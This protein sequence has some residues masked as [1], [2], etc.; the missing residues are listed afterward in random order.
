M[1]IS[2]FSAENKKRLSQQFRFGLESEYLVV[3][4]SDYQALWH[5][6]LSFEQLNG[7]FE[8]I[9]LDGIPSCEG[10]DLESPQTKLMP[11]VVEGYHLPDMDF[12]AKQILPKGVEIRTPVCNT[13]TQAL[14]IHSVLYKRLKQALNF[15]D[16]DLVSLSHH[17]H[18]S[19]FSG[20]Q[21]KRR[22]DYWQWSMEVMTTYGPDINVGI[23]EE[24]VRMISVDDLHQ[25]INYYGP[26]LS[27]L[28][29]ASPFCNGE[30]W[31][32]AK[33]KFGKSYRM[34]KRSYI[35][36]PIEIHFDENNRFEFKV[37]DMPNSRVE[38]EAQILSFLILII[39]DALTG[40]AT[41]QTRIY[42]L[43]EVAKKG[44]E[45]EGIVEKLHEI[46]NGAD[47]LLRE[48]GFD[49]KALSVFKE[50]LES[51]VTPADDMLKLYRVNDSIRD[52]LKQRSQFVF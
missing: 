5:Q 36:P 52:V 42:D 21:N 25:K 41:H 19:K 26:A 7:I 48:W 9:P 4:L 44:L 38:I 18:E 12:S 33:G 16:L 51:G 37:F 32:Y 3:T 2:S 31:Q 22:H 43:G 1:K 14:E 27:A 23:P 10:L 13:I 24:L 29:V 46:F 39:N 50:R 30:P 8:T 49:F 6:D 35:A 17:P 47:Q 11:F 34:H 15:H 40:R 28:S 20:P 45:A